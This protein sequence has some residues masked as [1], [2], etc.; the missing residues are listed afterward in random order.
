MSNDVI[1][2]LSDGGLKKGR[3]LTVVA[4]ARAGQGRWRINRGCGGGGRGRAG[5]VAGS[6]LS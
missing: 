3:R 2:E 4:E 5:Q 1:W 6:Q